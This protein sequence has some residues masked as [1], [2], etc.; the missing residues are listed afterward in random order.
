MNKKVKNAYKGLMLNFYYDM[1]KIAMIGVI[2]MLSMMVATIL[3]NVITLK[4]GSDI[5][6]NSGIMFSGFI[7]MMIT[8]FVYVIVSTSKVELYSK[9]SFPINRRIYAIANFIVLCAGSFALLMIVTI[10]SPV[11][12]G[13]YELLSTITDKF[14]Y[15]NNITLDGFINGFITCWL[16]L[17]TVSSVSYCIF[18]YIRKYM[19]VTLL[20]LAVVATIVIAFD[21]L[22]DVYRFLFLEKSVLLFAIKTLVISLVSH[23]LAY[24]PLKRLEVA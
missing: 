18:I 11:E 22:I 20:V 24:I 19:I 4:S 3:L 10:F 1:K 23:L 2:I 7:V 6:N 15:I 16:F 14:I 9:F 13:I 12:F 8:L 17:L 21:G 5:N